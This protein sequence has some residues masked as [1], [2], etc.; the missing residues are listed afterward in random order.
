MTFADACGV[1]SPTASFEGAVA[2]ASPVGFVPD[3]PFAL[4]SLPQAPP[5]QVRITCRTFYEIH[6]QVWCK[7]LPGGMAY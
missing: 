4:Q 1:H 3:L 2:L 5:P 7:I 6:C